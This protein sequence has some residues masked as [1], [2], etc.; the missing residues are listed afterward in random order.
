MEDKRITEIP[1]YLYAARTKDSFS[2]NDIIEINEA[3]QLV[4]TV[5]ENNRDFPIAVSLLVKGGV[6]YAPMRPK[7]AQIV[8]KKFRNAGYETTFESDVLTLNQP[9]NK[10]PKLEDPPSYS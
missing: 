1:L 9:T 10:K 2:Q 7:N 5:L 3:M 8:C 4:M 6:K